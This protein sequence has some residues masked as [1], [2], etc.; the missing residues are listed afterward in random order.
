MG[1]QDQSHVRRVSLAI[2]IR[3]P[4]RRHRRFRKSDRS[5]TAASER[6]PASASA[7]QLARTQSCTATTACRTGT[8][9]PPRTSPTDWGS[10]ERCIGDLSWW[11]QS[12]RRTYMI[13]LGLPTG[14]PPVCETGFKRF[15]NHVCSFMRGSTF[16]SATDRFQNCVSV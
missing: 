5:S 3:R 2:V 8:S 7:H 1:G 10:F 12:S 11:L 9:S 16:A 6:P 14:C 4:H 15:F 13:M